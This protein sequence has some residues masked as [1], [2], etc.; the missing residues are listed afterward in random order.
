MDPRERLAQNLV[1][2]SKAYGYTLSI[3]GSGAILFV[4]YGTPPSVVPIFSYV[5]GALVAFS[6]LAYVAFE[7][8]FRETETT[9][10]QQVMVSSIVHVLATFGN[11]IVSYLLVYV[12]ATVGLPAAISFLTVGFQATI[13]YNVLLLVEEGTARLLT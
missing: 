11:L 12:G 5:V 8:M 1:F 13:L 3:W 10:S 9:S 4:R 7:T 2:E 6:T